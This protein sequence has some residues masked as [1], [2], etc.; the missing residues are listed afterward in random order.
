MK[1]DFVKEFLKSNVQ[2][3]LQEV[4]KLLRQNSLIWWENCIVEAETGAVETYLR[5]HPLFTFRLQD[6]LATWIP[7]G[8]GAGDYPF[9]RSAYLGFAT[10]YDKRVFEFD[11][12]D[13]LNGS[14]S[15][16]KMILEL[17]NVTAALEIWLSTKESSYLPSYILSRIGQSFNLAILSKDQFRNVLDTL[18]H[19]V[20]HFRDTVTRP[21][22]AFDLQI[23]RSVQVQSFLKAAE[24]L[25]NMYFAAE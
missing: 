20:E 9:F 24:V 5:I 25:Q 19:V 11:D 23:S 7:R 2:D 18:D 22:D 15:R 21:A 16:E 4:L 8:A 1:H 3:Q 12:S 6:Y 14:I 10:Y 17:D 13:S